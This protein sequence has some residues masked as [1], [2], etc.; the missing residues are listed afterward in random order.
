MYLSAST[1]RLQRYS[2]RASVWQSLA[3]RA[4]GCLS[5]CHTLWHSHSARLL[6]TLSGWLA[7]NP[8]M[9]ND[10]RQHKKK[11]RE[12]PYMRGA[13]TSGQ[14]RRWDELNCMA[15]RK[16]QSLGSCANDMG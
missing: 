14:T 7:K 9:Y 13:W 8:K 12:I 11:T 1:N 3:A 2:P 10:Q 15:I 5:T 16:Y 4:G 6:H